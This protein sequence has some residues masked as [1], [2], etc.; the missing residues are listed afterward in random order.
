VFSDEIRILQGLQEKLGNAI[1]QVLGIRV[2]VT[3]VAPR[4]LAR[5]DGKAKRVQDRRNM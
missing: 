5:S 1:E 2:K 3:L 4:T